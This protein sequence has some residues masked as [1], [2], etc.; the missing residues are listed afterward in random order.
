MAKTT[1]ANYS[2]ELNQG[3]PGNPQTY[4]PLRPNQLGGRV[5]MEML[6]YVAAADATSSIALCKIP[7]GARLIDIAFAASAT[8]GGTATLSFGL[9]GADGSGNID[10]GPPTATPVNAADS[11]GAVVSDST[12]CLSG[13]YAYTATT[14]NHLLVPGAANYAASPAAEGVIS[15]ANGGWLYMTAK[16]VYLTTTVAAAALGTQV[17]QGY[18]LYALD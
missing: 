8:L 3:P 10:D 17:L 1:I 5:R 7:K 2:I 16:D 14:L 15:I 6:T 4:A 12:T 11:I 18:V 13:A 9:A